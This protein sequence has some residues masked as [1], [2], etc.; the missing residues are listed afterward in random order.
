M[1]NLSPACIYKA[2]ALILSLVSFSPSFTFANDDPTH[3]S[4]AE[5][6]RKSGYDFLWTV[7]QEE[8]DARTFDNATDREQYWQLVDTVIRTGSTYAQPFQNSSFGLTDLYPELLSL[9]TDPPLYVQYR[10]GSSQAQLG[11]DSPDEEYLEHAQSLVK[12][13]Q[14]MSESDYP[15][16]IEGATWI[17][18]AEFF[19]DAELQDSEVAQNARERGLQLLVKAASL[20]EIEPVYKEF[21]AI[22]LSR[23][24]WRYSAFTEKDKELYCRL[25]TENEHADPWIAHYAYGN[26]WSDR[27]WEARGDGWARDVSDKQWGL[28]YEYLAEAHGHLTLAW[29]IHPNWPESAVKLI[30]ETMGV[31]FHPD[32][33]EEFWFNE[34]VAARIDIQ[35]AYTRYAYAL[36]PRWG[37]NIKEMYELMD[38]V[39][40]LS[41]EQDHMGYILLEL[42]ASITKELEDGHAV[43]LDEKY[44]GI[45]TKLMHDEVNSQLPYKNKWQ[46]RSALRTVAMGQ[47]KSKNYVESAKLLGAGG[48]MTDRLYVPWQ[49]NKRFGQY[50]SLLATPAS[51]KIV[52]GLQAQDEDDSKAELKAFKEAC[53]HIKKKSSS[54]DPEILGDPLTIVEEI[55]DRLDPPSPMFS[56]AGGIARVV[57]MAALVILIGVWLVLR[58]LRKPSQ[59]S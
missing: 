55:V 18:A 26:L 32:R 17:R 19:R 23:F 7:I 5:S 57:S 6:F 15:F 35:R 9:D 37:G 28:Y 47:F 1:I 11:P 39:V 27:G 56:T 40:E 54:I 14:R 43:L 31:Q 12:I 44:L 59:A 45:A 2:I 8:F 30:G 48:G 22:R 42:M 46:F 10:Y 20:E 13:A 21:V 4:T 16:Y 38:S 34:A 33:D 51:D 41:N 53:R 58:V 49:E 52:D 24:G 3:H 29:E 25:L 50:A 36:A